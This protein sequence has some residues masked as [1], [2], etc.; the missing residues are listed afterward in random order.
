MSVEVRFTPEALKEPSVPVFGAEEIEEALRHFINEGSR[1][2]SVIC[3][4]NWPALVIEYRDDD[5]WAGSS[6]LLVHAR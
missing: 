2:L 4:G 5:S 3:F 6:V 1:N